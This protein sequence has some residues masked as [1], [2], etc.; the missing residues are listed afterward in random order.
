METTSDY[1]SHILYPMYLNYAQRSLIGGGKG[2]FIMENLKSSNSQFYSV[3][4]EDAKKIVNG[5][6]PSQYRAELNR[7][8]ASNL[9]NM[10]RTLDNQIK[11]TYE[12]ELSSDGE[13]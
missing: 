11:E 7:L 6:H 1:K 2:N 9:L 5:I 4:M 12:G 13:F 8:V 10:A 3:V